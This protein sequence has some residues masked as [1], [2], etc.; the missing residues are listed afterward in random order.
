MVRYIGKY[1]CKDC[2]Y[3]F[4]GADIEWNATA[5]SYPVKCPNCGSFHTAPRNLLRD[6]IL[7]KLFPRF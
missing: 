3:Q 1:V 6:V 2:G 4:I 5:A 7:R